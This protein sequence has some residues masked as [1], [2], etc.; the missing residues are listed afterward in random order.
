[1]KQLKFNTIDLRRIFDLITARYITEF[2]L[3]TADG[4]K[5]GMEVQKLMD[6]K[7]F[8]II[9]VKSNGEINGYV[10]TGKLT[11]GKC[12]GQMQSINNFD[13]VAESTP[14]LTLF[15]L[16]NNTKRKWFLVLESND[17][18]G[19]VAIGDLRK[20]PVRMFLYALVNLIEMYLTKMIR[21]YCK[22][23]ELSE[24]IKERLKDAEDIHKQ[25]KDKREDLDIF[26]C[27]QLCDKI[28]IALK[29]NTVFEKI[30]MDSKNKTESGLKKIEMLRNR[31]AHGNDIIAGTNWDEIFVIVDFIEKIIKKCEENDALTNL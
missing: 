21:E 29:K 27:L 23:E 19:I 26:D 14:I 12:L 31:L 16:F 28:T 6:S 13:L 2:E 22:E 30:K 18:K 17:V 3:V 15:D 1:M 25:R 7:N 5:D 8:D 9:P 4:E 11:L 10:E 24:L 20:A